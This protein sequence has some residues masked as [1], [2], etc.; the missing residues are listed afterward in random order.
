MSTEAQRLYELLPAIHRIRD[1]VIAGGQ[2]L[3]AP[4]MGQN[5]FTDRVHAWFRHPGGSSAARRRRGQ[6]E[7]RRPGPEQRLDD[8]PVQRGGARLG[9]R[10]AGELLAA[11]GPSV[12]AVPG[13]RRMTE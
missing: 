13:R 8:H 1:A 7:R 11:P 3:L 12:H 5:D 6:R 10:D 4:F 2:A 9:L